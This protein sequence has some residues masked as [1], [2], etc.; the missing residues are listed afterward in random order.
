M[1]SHSQPAGQQLIVNDLGMVMKELNQ[2]CVKWY[3]IGM[4]LGVEIYRLDAIKEQYSDPSDCLRETLKTWLK[5]YSSPTWSNI[6][7]S[8]RSSVVGEVRLADDMKHK[9]CSTENTSSAATRPVTP[10]PVT[11]QLTT[12]Q[13]L[14]PSATA[15][16]QYSVVPSATSS[17]ISDH[18]TPLP[19]M[20]AQPATEW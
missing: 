7:D 9:H 19:E 18:P 16:T 15:V 14:S 4:Q 5:T 11:V 6:V 13:H 3:N 20:P 17:A 2:A 8:L 1:M 12:S 10:T